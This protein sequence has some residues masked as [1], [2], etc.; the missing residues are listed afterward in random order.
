MLGRFHVFLL[1]AALAAATSGGAAEAPL[2]Q[3][4]RIEV[5]P[6]KTSIYVGSVALKV[7]P[8]TRS[9]GG[10]EAQYT[11]KV[12][13]YFFSNEAGKLRVDFADDA[14]RKLERGETVE[15]TGR[16][17][18]EDGE[19]RRVEGKATPAD[20]TS[21]KLKVRVRVTK[22]VELIF[23]TTYHFPTVQKTVAEAPSS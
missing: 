23:N 3:Y 6:V 18:N 20:P 1:G 5:A 12:F 14:L 8:M 21:G 22:K 7:P 11:A 2:S 9:N 4:D 16:A 19:E 13:P 10:Y 15:F 17:V